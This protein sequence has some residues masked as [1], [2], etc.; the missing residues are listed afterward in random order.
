VTKEELRRWVYLHNPKFPQCD[1]IVMKYDADK[2][3]YS[4]I[5][6]FEDEGKS[7]CA[8]FNDDD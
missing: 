5:R 3:K 2:G 8:K 1:E 4:I 6:N 7:F